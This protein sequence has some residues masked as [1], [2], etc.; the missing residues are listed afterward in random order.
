[1]MH[2]NRRTKRGKSRLAIE[3]GEEVVTE[4]DEVEGEVE[5]GSEAVGAAVDEAVAEAS[6]LWSW[7]GQRE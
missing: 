5:V 1:M 2:Q 7:K 4:V 3:V 6:K